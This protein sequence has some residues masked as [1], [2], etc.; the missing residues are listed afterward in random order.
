[1][2]PLDIIKQYYDPGS[3]LYVVLTGHSMAVA[4]LA[5]EIANKHPEL[6]ADV[7]FIFEAAMLH[8]IGIIR[9]DAPG[10]GCHGDMPYICHGMIGC[11]M[12]LEQGYERHAM[13]CERHTGA[14]ITADEIAEAGLP[15]PHRDFMPLTIE[16]KI[17]CYADKF[18]SKSRE[19]SYRKTFEEALKSVSKFGEASK[20]RFLQLH[21]L[22]K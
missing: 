4:E 9:T 8:D 6:N 18:F 14:G 13:I 15:L 11:M 2:K 10:I 16:E 3:E 17:I 5:V 20:E 19:L 21:E 7:Q 1:V 12:L 22:L